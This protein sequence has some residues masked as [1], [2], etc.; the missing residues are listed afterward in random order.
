MSPRSLGAFTPVRAYTNT[1]GF[2]LHSLCVTHSPTPAMLS[3]KNGHSETWVCVNGL[4][5]WDILDIL[6]PLYSFAVDKSDVQESVCRR[7][8]GESP[9]TLFK[10]SRSF[11]SC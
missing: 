10:K 2:F 8:T 4:D 9:Q 3:F 7:I 5:G 11:V 1:L 6:G